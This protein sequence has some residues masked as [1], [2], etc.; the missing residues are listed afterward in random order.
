MT[1]LKIGEIILD[2]NHLLLLYVF[3]PKYLTLLRIYTPLTLS[4][5]PV[6]RGEVREYLHLISLYC[7][8]VEATFLVMGPLF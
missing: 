1:H 8:M 6:G 5:P 4:L 2:P 7:C 3:T